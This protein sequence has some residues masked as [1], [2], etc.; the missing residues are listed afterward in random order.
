[1]LVDLARNDLSRQSNEVRIDKLQEIQMYSHVIHIVSHVSATLHGHPID[2]Y[3]DTFPAGTL[4]GAPKIRA[5]QII[6]E[7]EPSARGFYGGAVGFLG[8]NGDIVHAIIIRSALSTQNT[9]H[10]QAGAGVVIHS[11]A[12]KECQEVYHKV[13]AVQQA[14]REAEQIVTK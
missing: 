12:Q 1:M 7:Q 2:M 14:I 5:M 8:F 10:Y 6:D 4:S 11:D 3:T 9:L 13:G